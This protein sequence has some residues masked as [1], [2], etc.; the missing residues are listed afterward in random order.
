MC[1]QQVGLPGWWVT[2]LNLQVRSWKMKKTYLYEITVKMW[3]QEL[4]AKSSSGFSSCTLVVKHHL[5]FSS[6]KHNFYLNP[7][8]V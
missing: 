8:S 3:S 6:L 5:V 4:Q 1:G 7:H 2:S